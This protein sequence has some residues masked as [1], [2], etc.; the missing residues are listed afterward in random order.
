MC[1]KRTNCFFCIPIYIS[2][3]QILVSITIISNLRVTGT[4][5]S[6]STS[7]CPNWFLSYISLISPG[8]FSLVI[9]M[10]HILKSVPKWLQQLTDQ[11]YGALLCLTWKCIGVWYIFVRSDFNG[12]IGLL[13]A[14]AGYSAQRDPVLRSGNTTWRLQAIYTAIMEIWTMKPTNFKLSKTSVIDKKH[15]T[16]TT[17]SWFFSL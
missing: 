6:N 13:R 5:N 14:S 10:F 17:S 4:T 11:N 2:L 8:Y 7:L 9:S 1:I 12:S 16:A 15:I 3:F